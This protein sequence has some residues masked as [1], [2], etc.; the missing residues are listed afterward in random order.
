MPAAS[1]LLQRRVKIMN[2]Y[3]KFEDVRCVCEQV[4]LLMDI[5][6]CV[7]NIF[8]WEGGGDGR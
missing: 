8:L 1:I 7:N 3:I 6:V 2:K 5:E 4:T